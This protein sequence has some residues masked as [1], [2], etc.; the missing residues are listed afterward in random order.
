MSNRLP[1]LVTEIRQSHERALVA[2]RS[3][4]E[5]AR[6]SGDALIEAKALVGH[7]EWLPF[8]KETGVSE[9]TAQR[10]MKIA[11]NWQAIAGKTTS[12]SDLSVNEALR[13]LDGRDELE[14][15]L[16][17]QAEAEALQQE[18]NFLKST[19][20]TADVGG[21]HFIIARTEELHKKAVV[22]RATAIR[23]FGRIKSEMEQTG[24]AV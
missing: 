16:V 18:L 8:L 6:Q 21:L 1:I 7:G 23:E 5:A 19:V 4:A 24:G 17:L 9:R 14:R 13:L 10:Y 22:I 15:A 11:K 20:D 12:V 3:A 2:L